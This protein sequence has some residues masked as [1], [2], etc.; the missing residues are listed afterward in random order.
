MSLASAPPPKVATAGRPSPTRIAFWLACALS[1]LVIGTLS[2]AVLFDGDPPE[3]SDLLSIPSPPL[4]PEANGIV[5][6]EELV[7]VCPRHVHTLEFKVRQVAMV[8]GRVSYVRDLTE[9]QFLSRMEEI[10]LLEWRHVR[11]IREWKLCLEYVQMRVT[12][13]LAGLKLE[14]S[15]EF[16]ILGIGCERRLFESRDSALGLDKEFEVERTSYRALRDLIAETVGIDPH[17]CLSALQRLPD[18]EADLDRV[19]QRVYAAHRRYLSKREKTRHFKP[20]RVL[21]AVAAELRIWIDEIDQPWADRGSIEQRKIRGPRR[22]MRFLSG[23]A[24]GD[25]WWAGERARFFAFE[26][27][28]ALVRFDRRAMEIAL[29]LEI[30]RRE[31]GE[32]PERLEALTPDILETLPLDPFSGEDFLYERERGVVR[33][34]GTDAGILRGLPPEPRDPIDPEDPVVVTA[35]L[36]P[37]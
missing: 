8:D 2:Q 37:R 3:D 23:N 10:V 31:H 16:V 11:R 20:N 21:S 24:R 9:D 18:P 35:D 4:A 6:M 19:L 1:A 25:G 22:L 28:L 5:A 27:N 36:F 30:Y 29:A 14:N 15:L 33:S 17:A 26:R 7:K 13:T 34:V 12:D 32:F